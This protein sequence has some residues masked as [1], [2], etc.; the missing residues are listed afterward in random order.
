[1][2]K[3]VT[4]FSISSHTVPDNPWGYFY[5]EGI[6]AISAEYLK[7]VGIS[8]KSECHA[9]EKPHRQ[10]VYV[11]WSNGDP[12]P[13]CGISGSVSLR[14]TLFTV[15]VICGKPIGPRDRKTSQTPWHPWTTGYLQPSHINFTSSSPHSMAQILLFQHKLNVALG[16]T[17]VLGKPLLPISWHFISFF[18]FPDSQIFFF[19]FA[20]SVIFLKK[21]AFLHNPKM[22]L[23]MRK[24]SLQ[25][26]VLT[27][28]QE[29]WN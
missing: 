3:A 28:I 19:K 17:L 23:S 27:L 22:T 16:N 4:S 25:V 7:F 9:T 11:Y 12:G 13:A 18:M 14:I 10:L 2:K 29:S 15:Y 24:I 5:W 21:C 1:M 20:R 26:K 6:S 8:I